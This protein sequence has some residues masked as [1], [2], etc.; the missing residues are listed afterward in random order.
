MGDPRVPIDP[1]EAERR[2][3]EMLAR[4]GLPR[5][6]S[7]FHDPATDELA[8]TWDHGLTIRTR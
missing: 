1:D 7:T 5:F 8:L 4:A 6:A 3:A 2:F